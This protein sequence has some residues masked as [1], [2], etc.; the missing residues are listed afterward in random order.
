MT[1]RKVVYASSQSSSV[2]DGPI[3][4]GC[5]PKSTI[6]LQDCNVLRIRTLKIPNDQP[7]A[8]TG[9]CLVKL[10]FYPSSSWHT[11]D[12]SRKQMAMTEVVT[13]GGMLVCPIRRRIPI[14]LLEYLQRERP[15]LPL[16]MP[17]IWNPINV[18]TAPLPIYHICPVAQQICREL[19]RQRTFYATASHESGYGDS[20]V[21]NI[22]QHMSVKTLI[23]CRN[24]RVR[25]R[26]LARARILEP[27]RWVKYTPRFSCESAHPRDNDV[28]LVTIHH[29]ASCSSVMN[30]FDLCIFVTHDT[31]PYKWTWVK[32]LPSNHDRPQQPRLLG[33]MY[34]TLQT[35]YKKHPEGVQQ[36][37]SLFGNKGIEYVG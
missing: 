37:L 7:C 19:Q 32:Q 14:G 6:T 2:Y 33:I 31:M 3:P 11:N 35:V 13:E 9:F 36:F 1:A 16:P 23:I 15:N 34:N 22:V 25:N 30:T 20:L 5:L 26:L 28:V 10:S 24:V 4:S 12:Y 29:L 27:K 17:L 8:A 18:L 21:Y